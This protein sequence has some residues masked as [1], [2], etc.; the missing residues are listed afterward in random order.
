MILATASSV[1]APLAPPLELSAAFNPKPVHVQLRELAAFAESED[2][3]LIQDAYGQG[4][5]L[6]SFEAE[7]AAALGKEKAL[8]FPTGVAAQNAALC[9][10]AG[11]PAARSADFTTPRP[12]FM[13]H[14]TSHLL[15]YEED[16]YRALLGMTALKVG[17]AS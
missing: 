12:S 11:L 17:A 15:L 5:W 4:E 7:I 1:G 9:V 10:H 8:F 2:E 16:A 14:P 6:Q 13:T 3:L